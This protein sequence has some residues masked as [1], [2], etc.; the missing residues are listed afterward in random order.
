M[1]SSHFSHCHSREDQRDWQESRV[2]CV[3]S[4][5]SGWVGC[6]PDAIQRLLHWGEGFSH[7]SWLPCAVHCKMRAREPAS[8]P[9]WCVKSAGPLLRRQRM[10]QTPGTSPMFQQRGST[11]SLQSKSAKIKFLP[12]VRSTQVSTEH[13]PGNRKSQRLST[14]TAASW[15]WTLKPIATVTAKLAREDASF[16]KEGV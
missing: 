7:H 5:G 1:I 12:P 2:T 8:K 14:L 11:F 16:I 10:L 4:G 3:G 13:G 6:L 9:G 15:H